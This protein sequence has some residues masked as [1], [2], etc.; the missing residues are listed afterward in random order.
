MVSV[1][2][3]GPLTRFSQGN[4]RLTGWQMYMHLKY[5]WVGA[6]I[7]LFTASVHVAVTSITSLTPTRPAGA[8]FAHTRFCLTYPADCRE[9]SKKDTIKTITLTPKLRTEL[10]EV[11]TRVN[12]KI[13][14]EAQSTT[15][16]TEQWIIDPVTGDCNDYA[17]TKRHRLIQKGWPANALLLAEVVLPSGEHHLVLIARTSEGDLVLDNLKSELRTIA[18][19]G[20]SY[21]WVRMES[22]QNP[23]FWTEV[24]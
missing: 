21:K 15:P 10:N 8:P 24:N 5:I 1:G 4:L 16:S 23:L 6:G 18:E 12:E 3:S 20:R 9:N 22:P 7:V 14:P 11:N 2:T 13:I 17:V 19:V